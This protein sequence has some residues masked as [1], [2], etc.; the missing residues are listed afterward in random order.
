[1]AVKGE[2]KV[3]WAGEMTRIQEELERDEHRDRLHKDELLG[4]SERGMS[5]KREQ[6]Q[7]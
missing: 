7:D 1:M 4:R 3:P 2:Q 6:E 5:G